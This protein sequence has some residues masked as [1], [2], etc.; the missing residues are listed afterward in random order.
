MTSSA[1][2]PEALIKRFDVPPCPTVISELQ[3]ELGKENSSPVRIAR[4][5]SRDVG[6]SGAV[7][8]LVNS[9]AFH[10]GTEVASISE[11]LS[12]LGADRVF[13]LVVGELLRKS[14]GS[15]HGLRLDRYWDSAACCAETCAAIADRLPGT[16]RET[17]Y[18]FGLFHDCGIPLLMRRFPDYRQ[19]LQAANS[20][21]GLGLIA[22]EEQRHNTNHADIGYLLAR[23]WGLSEVLCEAI[24]SHHNYEVLDPR[25]HAHLP[26][27]ACTLIA[28]NAIADHVTSLH[29]RTREEGQWP[30]ARGCVAA[31][32]GLGSDGLDDLVDDLLHDMQLAVPV[33]AVDAS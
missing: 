17:A 16:T 21:I 14:I 9:P 4:L 1:L 25:R 22:M 33:P 30:A 5:I 23:T 31:F 29:L 13:D 20:E 11:A 3:A 7:M 8:R 24:R 27:E 18:C 19:T 10:A 28:V 15:D 6:L 26:D 32:F 2:A 12:I